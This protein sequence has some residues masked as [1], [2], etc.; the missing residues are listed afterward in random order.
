MHDYIRDHVG[1]R[2]LKYAEII[3]KAQG[4][5]QSVSIQLNDDAPEDIA[6]QEV[7]VIKYSYECLVLI[8]E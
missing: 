6:L 1:S 8:A 3:L 7:Y 2:E 5:H 4:D